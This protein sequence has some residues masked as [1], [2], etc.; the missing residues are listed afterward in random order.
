MKRKEVL[1]DKSCLP[2]PPV[3]AEQVAWDGLLSPVYEVLTWS[4]V[5]LNADMQMWPLRTD[6]QRQHHL[7]AKCLL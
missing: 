5:F 4:K 2:R 3:D 1:S 6:C 7:Q